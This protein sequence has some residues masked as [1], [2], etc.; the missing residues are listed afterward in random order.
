MAGRDASYWIESLALVE[1]PEGGHYRETYR[2]S[3][4]VTASGADDGPPAGRSFSTAIY[5]LLRSGE[6]SRLHRLRSD[7]VFH[8]Y[9]GSALVIHS[10]D[11]AG[12]HRKVTLGGD[13]ERGEVLQAVIPAG[14]WFGATVETPDSFALVGCTVAPGFDFDD[15]ELAD[16]DRLLAL[17]P[18]HRT[19]IERLT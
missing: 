8:H 5:Y 7:E 4:T 11:S 18:H 14:C 3:R 15:F 13:P 16:R 1:H 9:R 12:E 2:S 19:I 10:I 17:Y 6:I